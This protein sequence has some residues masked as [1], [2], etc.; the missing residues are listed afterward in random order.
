MSK[1]ASR[2]VPVE[3]IKASAS[4]KESAT[5]I[6]QVLENRL[7][8]LREELGLRAE[9]HIVKADR[10]PELVASTAD[11][12]APGDQYPWADRLQQEIKDGSSSS[13]LYKRDDRFVISSMLPLAMPGELPTAYLVVDSNEN[14]TVLKVASFAFHYV[15]LFIGLVI[16][17][18]AGFAYFLRYYKFR[19]RQLQA[20][21]NQIYE[22]S[23]DVFFELD[24]KLQLESM[25]PR[26][27]EVLDSSIDDLTGREFLDAEMQKTMIPM[28]QSASSI[29]EKILAG[30]NFQF[31]LKIVQPNSGVRYY[32]ALAFC[33][34]GK[35]CHLVLQDIS[36]TLP[37]DENALDVDFLLDDPSFFDPLTKLPNLNFLRSSLK[38]NIELLRAKKASMLLIDLDDFQYFNHLHG[39]EEGD[40]LLQDFASK[41]SGF[42][43]QSD[44]IVRYADDKFVILL[45]QT[46]LQDAAN[47]AN[48][49]S[50]QMMMSDHE[51]I[52]H[53]RFSI[54]VA[55]VGE[56][57]TAEDW[58][59]RAIAAL[60]TAKNSG[61]A[62][63]EAQIENELQILN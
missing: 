16:V 35:S 59:N 15:F 58:I 31:K 47:I 12:L 22:N 7:N 60:E 10:F 52:K 24:S 40:Q 27:A 1:A 43:R 8:Q 18:V 21:I 49:M 5:I 4:T 14:P 26:A 38:S 23:K 32:Q 25:N 39:K 45:P 62:R 53:T 34:K 13:E 42:F 37:Q 2:L 41:L 57:D 20:Q 48:N 11:N 29:R 3:E 44:K 61:K 33:E 17:G 46:K 55:Q 36:Q 50:K 19:N 28:D 30:R 51:K 63:V 54:G 6:R 9:L 56:Q